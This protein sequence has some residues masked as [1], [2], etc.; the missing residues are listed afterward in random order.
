MASTKEVLHISET[1][2][3]RSDKWHS[4]TRAEEK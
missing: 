3:S 4:H 1:C 2:S